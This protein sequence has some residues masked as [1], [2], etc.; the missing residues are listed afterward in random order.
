[1]HR[2]IPGL[3]TISIFLT[4]ISLSLPAHS[5][6]KDFSYL[7]LGFSILTLNEESQVTTSHQ[8]QESF[9]RLPGLNISISLQPVK[10]LFAFYET[11]YF[12]DREGGAELTVKRSYYGGGTQ[13]TLSNNLDL[14]GKLYRVK[15]EV[16]ACGSSCSSANNDGRGSD[17]GFIYRFD[18]SLAF[19]L[20]YKNLNLDVK[21]DSAIHAALDIRT[22][23]RRNYYLAFTDY[24]DRQ[25]TLAWRFHF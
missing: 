14:Y 11:E 23:S 18:H 13:L 22:N 24:D 4:L 17:L 6:N 15:R 3:K 9:S 8:S 16:E 19:K 20:G 2:S 21:N 12:M 7:Q 5:E 10:P 25:L 1:M